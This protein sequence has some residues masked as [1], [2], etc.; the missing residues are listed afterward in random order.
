MIRFWPAEECFGIAYVQC[1]DCYHVLCCTNVISTAAQLMSQNNQT[2]TSIHSH[3]HRDLVARCPL[4]RSLQ[5]AVEGLV[6]TET[7]LPTFLLNSALQNI[8]ASIALS[9]QAMDH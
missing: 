9:S 5:E 4:A 2:K 1:S 7:R 8:I 6:K 3:G